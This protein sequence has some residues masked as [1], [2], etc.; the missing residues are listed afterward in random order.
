LSQNRQV[1]RKLRA[2]EAKKALPKYSTIHTVLPDRPAFLAFVRMSGETRPWG[3][4]FGSEES[5]P[6]FTSV[7][8]GRDWSAI[9]SMIEG[10]S[11]DFIQYFRVENFTFD[12]IN[13]DNL[14]LDNPPQIWVP[15]SSHIDMLHFLNYMFW[16]SRSDDAMDAHRTTLARLCGWLFRESKFTGQQLI[17]D[18]GAV[19]RAN[20][21]FPVD[22]M[23]VS[24][25]GAALGWLSEKES[26]NLQV[27][28]A[29][30]YGQDAAGTTLEPEVERKLERLLRNK[31]ENELEI[32]LIINEEL[33]RRWSIAVSTY[34][35]LKKDSR[36]VNPGANLLLAD[37]LKR[38]V[39]NFQ[40]PELKRQDESLA[41]AFTPHP[42]TDN[43]GSAAAASYYE[44]QGADSK[45]LPA[46]VHH[47]EELLKDSLFSGFAIAG[48]VMNVT[49]VPSGPRKKEIFWVLRVEARDD[50]RIREGE[51]L[52][53]MGSPEHSVKVTALE[54]VDETQIDLTLHWKNRKT[55][56]LG[57]DALK[58]PGADIWLSEKV[59]FVPLDSSEFDKQAKSK[60]WSAREG[61]G[62]WLTHGN[63]TIS[64]DAAVLDDVKQIEG[65]K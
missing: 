32:S 58:V 14:P 21:V 64:P 4:A 6:N 5:G 40:G 60:V 11:M 53:P 3:I 24:N 28:E 56:A 15:N 65:D 16:K 57:D 44:L 20:Y 47:D 48:N 29:R 42:E 55:M 38:Y 59:Y 46:L 27:A 54:F 22:D 34:R 37:S 45:L 50:F 49:T 1:I 23:S 41:P 62:A 19:L 10:F 7:A 52:A 13:K 30:Q 26:I 25:P 33:E 43:H 61:R 36:K 17:V 8:D 63:S 12:P 2:F 35:A 51:S 31:A 39:Y 18:S 9:Q